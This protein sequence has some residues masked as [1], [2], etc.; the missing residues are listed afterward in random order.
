MQASS[1]L[2]NTEIVKNIL[3]DILE[4]EPADLTEDGL[5][6]EEYG[7]DSLRAVEIL[8]SLEKRFNLKLPEKELKN[9]VN[10]RQ[11]KQVLQQ[12]GWIA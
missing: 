12:Y 8:A 11:V 9:M 2:S 7:A 5:F 3:C 1:A 4:V 10:L 6:I